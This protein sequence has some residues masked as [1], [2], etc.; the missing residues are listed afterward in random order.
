MDANLGQA[1]SIFFTIVLYEFAF[2]YI[3]IFIYY[4]QKLTFLLF[5]FDHLCYVLNTNTAK[6]PVSPLLTKLITDTANYCY[7]CNYLNN[8]TF[9]KNVSTQYSTSQSLSLYV[10]LCLCYILAG[11]ATGYR[12]DRRGSIPGWDKKL[13]LLHKVQIVGPTQSLLVWAPEVLS[14]R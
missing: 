6:Q 4:R 11:K 7:V 5:R 13:S 1:L 10:M 9:L 14:R 8:H 12:L 2:L 3:F